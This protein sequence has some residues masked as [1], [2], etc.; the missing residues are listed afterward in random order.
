MRSYFLLL[1]CAACADPAHDEVVVAHWNLGDEQAIRI[2]SP[3]FAGQPTPITIVS[4][5]NDCVSLHST[6][7]EVAGDVVDITPYDRRFSTDDFCSDIGLTFEH[8]VTVVFPQT[9]S[10]TAL[11]RIHGSY[12]ERGH[13]LIERDI[14]V[15]LLGY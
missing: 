9:P 1:V 5:G 4:D 8:T 3:I 2:P 15:P 12:D 14:V 10:K 11:L 6:E 13:V 7:V